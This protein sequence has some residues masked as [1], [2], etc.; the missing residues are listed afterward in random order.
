MSMFQFHLST[1]TEQQLDRLKFWFLAANM[2][3][4]KPIIHA[5]KLVSCRINSS[6]IFLY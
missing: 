6:Y 4:A 1:Q 5:I 2:I 3:D